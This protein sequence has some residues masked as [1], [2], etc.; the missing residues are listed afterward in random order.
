ML[1]SHSNSFSPSILARLE[2]AAKNDGAPAV[3][4]AEQECAQVPHL[5]A[6]LPSRDDSVA[7]IQHLPPELLMKVFIECLPQA[8]ESCSPSI[9]PLLLGQI[10]R[11]WRAVALA[12]SYIWSRI[13]V[14][15]NFRGVK[16]Q[17]SWVESW[18]KRSKESPL[19]ISIRW[20]RSPAGFHPVFNSVL[21][22]VHRWED[23][24]IQLPRVFFDSLASDKPSLPTLRKLRIHVTSGSPLPNWFDVFSVAPKLRRVALCT[25]SGAIQL[26]WKHLTHCTVSSNM[27]DCLAIMHKS[28]HLIVCA[29]E[30]CTS[31]SWSPT[32][33]LEVLPVVSYISSLQIIQ[34][35]RCIQ[36]TRC[37]CG[38]IFSSLTLPA[39]RNLSIKFIGGTPWAHAE[40]MALHNRSFF[41]LE[42]L[43][44]ISVTFLYD[45]LISLLQALPSLIEIE[46]DS[47]HAIY[48]VDRIPIVDNNLLEFLTYNTISTNSAQLVILPRLQVIKLWGRLHCNDN[49]L[50]NMI[51]S[52]WQRPP[53]NLARLQ[54]VGLNCRRPWDAQ[55]MS[56]LEKFQEE[57]LN[58]LLEEVPLRWQD[59][60]STWPKPGHTVRK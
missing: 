21:R 55:E 58:L 4:K 44:L 1:G 20:Y 59:A 10:C 8:P 6:C 52:R 45:D 32:P 15:L 46:I 38:E 31:S 7:L 54:Y 47:V 18:L 23:V 43:A 25:G 29:M 14:S 39:L 49:T 57:R 48:S 24:D 16:A 2:D 30:D 50:V 27:T 36:A 41:L 34:T 12:T 37:D 40:F 5:P 35:T 17:R 42:R 51:Q 19:S 33:L 9:A 22:H 3:C 56:R 13:H 53:P 26:P 11:Y 28:P 60:L